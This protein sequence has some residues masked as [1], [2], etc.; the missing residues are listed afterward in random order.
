ML[1]CHFDLQLMTQFDSHQFIFYPNGSYVLTPRPVP[2]DLPVTVFI[3]NWDQLPPG[4]VIH[5]PASLTDIDS[6]ND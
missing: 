1:V 5:Q 6:D 4:P 3:Y 2:F